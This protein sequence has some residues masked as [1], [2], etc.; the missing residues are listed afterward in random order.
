MKTS[1]RTS[2]ATFLIFLIGP[3][4]L[5]QTD[6]L[7][8]LDKEAASWKPF[9][10]DVH[11]IVRGEGSLA[12]QGDGGFFSWG[13]R[14]GER[15]YTV[16]YA[17]GNF[18]YVSQALGCSETKEDCTTLTVSGKDGFFEQTGG[19]G[20]VSSS[21]RS[22]VQIQLFG[23]FWNSQPLAYHLRNST[24]L[25][26]TQSPN[27]TI[28]EG[29]IA[30]MGNTRLT[31][32]K[33]ARIA[34]ATSEGVEVTF[35]NYRTVGTSQIPTVIIRQVDRNGIHATTTYHLTNIRPLPADTTL[36]MAWQP[37]TIIFDGTTGR[38]YVADGKGK[39]VLNLAAE[40]AKRRADR[41]DSQRLLTLVGSCAV[42]F[43]G[44][45]FKKMN[46]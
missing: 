23:P 25:D 26:V 17:N 32:D 1:S 41:N 6:F 30:S 37:K 3:S 29:K 39:P 28:V 43:L 15:T 46:S 36:K 8:R 9:T 42:L 38:E 11:E 34:Q 12:R 40:L 2:L 21:C 14:D 7:N 45:F 5:G 44:I 18:R 20:H 22:G 13:D 27:E 33:L 16:T 10:A 19:I 31:F 24:N 4:A 35:S